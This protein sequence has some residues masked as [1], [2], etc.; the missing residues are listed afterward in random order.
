MLNAQEFQALVLILQRAPITAAEAVGLQ[1]IVEKLKP[2]V[3]KE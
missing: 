3:P 2:V 1:V